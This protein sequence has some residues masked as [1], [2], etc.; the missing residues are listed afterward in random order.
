MGDRYMRRDDGGGN[1]GWGL[2]HHSHARSWGGEVTAG[3]WLRGRN[4][5]RDNHS[6][7]ELLRHSTVNHTRNFYVDHGRRCGK[8]FHWNPVDGGG[9]NCLGMDFY[10]PR[11]R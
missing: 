4:H 2:A 3:T 10:P 11:N 1:G 9:T 7:R 6:S 5:R 8:T